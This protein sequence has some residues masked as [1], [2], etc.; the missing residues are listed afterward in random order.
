[1]TAENR[2]LLDV[3]GARQRLGEMIIIVVRRSRGTGESPQLTYLAAWERECWR[4]Q[5]AVGRLSKTARTK[6]STRFGPRFRG[7]GDCRFLRVGDRIEV[8]ASLASARHAYE[9]W[10]QRHPGA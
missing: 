10:C 1:M 7:S 9:A 8:A 3:L 2:H 6:F 5:M 4:V